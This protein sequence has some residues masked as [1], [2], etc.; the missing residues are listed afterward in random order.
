MSL[1]SDSRSF[2]VSMMSREMLIGEMCWN[3]DCKISH[4]S[5]AFLPS[6]AAWCWEATEFLMMFSALL[7][8]ARCSRIS[9]DN[10]VQSAW[11]VMSVGV[12]PIDMISS[13]TKSFVGS[14][15]PVTAQA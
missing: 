15:L 13:L 12:K 9:V 6:M 5:L 14:G 8:A 3:F 7:K 11:V 1:Q 10:A 4:I 2:I